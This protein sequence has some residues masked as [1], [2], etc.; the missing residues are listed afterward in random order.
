MRTKR[1]SIHG[2]LHYFP[3]VR[4]VYEYNGQQY[5]GKRIKFGTPQLYPSKVVACANHPY[6]L[7]QEVEVFVNPFH[8]DQSV[9][10]RRVSLETISPILVGGA[11]TFVSVLGL[12]LI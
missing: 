9:L 11:V 5:K 12:F 1:V 3:A 6:E 7:D 8:P 4:Y 2:H 10:T